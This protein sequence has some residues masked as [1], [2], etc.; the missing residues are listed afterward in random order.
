[1]AKSA[2]PPAEAPADATAAAADGPPAVPDPA[3]GMKKRL[4]IIGVITAV[5]WAFAIQTGSLVLLIIV[6]VLTAVLLGVILW[7][8]GQIKKQRR[9]LGLL[10]GATGSPEARRD[11]L[12]KLSEDKDAKSPTKIFAR[13]QLL[14]ADDPKA[15]LV[16]LE[17]VELKSYPGQMQD[18]VSLLKVQLYLGTGR[19]QEAR[20]AADTMN[21]DNPSRKETRPLAASIVAEAWARTGKPKEALALIETIEPPKKNGEQIVLQARV[22]KVFA[23][24]A[25]NQRG[26]AKQEMTALADE[27]VN[28]L[29]RFLAPQFRVHP[30][31]Q[32]LARQVYESHPSA[33]KAGKSAAKQSRIGR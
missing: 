11:A 6:G 8:W 20:K 14:A 5:V 15:A 32:K 12:A 27:D 33:R 22:A 4:I 26:P 16:L 31:L 10:Q 23:K 19:T 29:G 17:S 25:T 3:A 13:S 18:D 2:P 21:L 9:M 7:A 24:F 1:V 30:E 28:H